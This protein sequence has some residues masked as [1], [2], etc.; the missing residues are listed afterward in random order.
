MRGLLSLG[1]LLCLAVP[2]CG[3]WQFLSM[4]I[5]KIKEQVSI[6]IS[7]GIEIDQ[8]VIFSFT[9]STIHK[10][11]W[12]HSREFEYEGEMYD[13]IRSEVNGETTTYWCY[14]DRTE[15]KVKNEIR[16]LIARALGQTPQTQN[17]QSHINNFFK[18]LYPVSQQQL[19][20]S[21][22]FTKNYEGIK[23]YFFPASTFS[24]NPPVPPPKTC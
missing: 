4:Q 14:H 10:I 3:A 8:Q 23:I 12:E 1:L 17:K 15:T 5:L 21:S 9:E 7:E 18:T 20:S 2:F 19:F 22:T 6:R 11:K 16:L 13:V 24:L